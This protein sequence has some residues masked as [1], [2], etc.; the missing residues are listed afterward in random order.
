MRVL[1]AVRA[2]LVWARNEFMGEYSA[3]PHQCWGNA[4]ESGS[5]S[6]FPRRDSARYVQGVRWCAWCW[7]GRKVPAFAGI[8]RPRT[9]IERCNACLIEATEGRFHGV[10][11]LRAHGLY[12]LGKD[13]YREVGTQLLRKPS[14]N[15]Q[16][17]EVHRIRAV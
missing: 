9:G 2:A 5:P 3:R 4:I 8:M 7:E 13:V 10:E 15:R 11:V 17:K 1:E 12:I 16:R 6:W 14:E